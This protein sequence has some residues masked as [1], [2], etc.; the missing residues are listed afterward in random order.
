[1]LTVPADPL[2]ETW[3]IEEPAT[4]T[5]GE[6]VDLADIDGDNDTDVLLGTVWLAQQPD[7][8]YADHTLFTTTDAADRNDL[9][10]INDDGRLDAVIAYEGANTLKPVAWY[11]APLDRTQPWT[12]HLIAEVVGPMSMDV[13]DFDN[14]GDPDVVVGEHTTND[15]TAGRV[16]VFENE[17]GVGG[18]WVQH[19]VATGHEHHDGTQ[20]VDIDGDGDKD[21]ISIGWNN[22]DLMLYEQVNCGDPGPTPTPL[23][24]PIP[25][26]TPTE[27]ATATATT[28]PTPGPSPTATETLTPTMTATATATG[29]ATPTATATGTATPVPTATPTSEPTVPPAAQ[30]IYLSSS[31]NGSVQGVSFRD[32]DILIFDQ[33]SG[34]WSLH[35]DGSDVGLARTD[36]NAFLLL[37]DGSLLLSLASP[38][39]DLPGLGAVDDS[40]IIRFVATSWGENTSGVVQLVC[41]RIGH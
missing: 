28:E 12:E 14:D 18:N 1:M 5:L 22:N 34:N 37:D 26:E 36:V 19:I 33:I 7:G 6:D 27:T 35:F 16:I 31:S 29:T 3:T 4:V 41:R 25:T 21:I 15:P 32:E 13:A 40:D 8:S 9:A 30:P 2:T 10:D 11:E 20:A 24:T 23:P 17:D 38:I 39:D